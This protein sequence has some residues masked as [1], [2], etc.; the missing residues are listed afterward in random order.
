MIT[1]SAPISRATAV[2]SPTISSFVFGKIDCAAG[3]L[4]QRGEPLL[5]LFQIVFVRFALPAHRRIE[6]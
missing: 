6:A 3:F 2:A 4:G 1:Y 5:T